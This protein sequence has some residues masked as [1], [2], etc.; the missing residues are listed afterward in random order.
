MLKSIDLINR[1]EEELQQK[2][3]KS[4]IED[5][6]IELRINNKIDVYIVSNKHTKIEQLDIQL[7][8]ENE[9]KNAN[10]KIIFINKERSTNEEYSHLFSGVRVSLGLRRSLN[11]LLNTSN[12]RDNEKN[13]ITFYSYKGGVGRTTSLALT[14]T[15]LSRKGK[16][17]FVIDCDFEAPGLLNFFNS[18][19]ADNCKNGL[20]EYLNDQKFD[21]DTQLSDYVYNIEKNYSGAGIINLIPAGNILS[22]QSDTLSYL[23]GLAKVDFQ[24]D[25]LISLMLKLINE[26]NSNYNP[27]VVLIDSRTGFNNI[28]GALAHISKH[29]VVLAGDDVQNQPG[30]EYVTS[31]LDTKDV[32]AT[33]VLSVISS[34]FSRRANNFKNY[35]QGLS[36]SNTDVDVFYFDR[37]NALEYI[38]T[39][40]E[41]TYDIDD[42]INGEN[43][44][45]QYHNFFQH[46]D[47]IVNHFKDNSVQDTNIKD[48]FDIEDELDLDIEDEDED[49]LNTIIN[50]VNHATNELSTVNTINSIQDIVL[51]NIRTKLPDLYAENINY[52]KEYIDKHFYYRPC[53]EDLLIP[54]KSILLGDKG[55]GKTAFYKALQ[56]NVFFEQ[57]VI[58]AQKQH[59]NYNVVNITNFEI[60]NF[61][62]LGFDE[63][64]KNELFIK[65]FWLFYIWN[66]LCSRHDVKTEFSYNLIELGRPD[67]SRKIISL[68]NNEGE[69]QKI[70][71]EL[72]SIN[73]DLK[74]HDRRLIITFDQLD[75]I[76]KPILW[77]DVVS[78]LVKM[79][80]RFSYSNIHPKLFLRRDLYDRLGNL[81]NKNSFISRVINLEW[82]Q[83]EIF[84]YF[85]KI[86]FTYSNDSFFSFLEYGKITRAFLKNLAKKL[87]TKSKVHNQLPLDRA[88]I[89]P[90]I[91][92]FFGSPR[93]NKRGKLS[94]AYQ[95]L[96]R[97]IQSADR[98]VNLRPFIDLLTNAIQEQDEQDE[99]KKFRKGAI[100]G[101]AYCTSSTVRKNAVVKYLEDLWNEQG[102]EFVKCFCVDFSKNKVDEQFKRSN[103]TEESFEMLLQQIKINNADEYPDISV[104][105]LDDLKQI[106]IATKIVTPYMVGNK[107]RYRIAYLYTNYLGV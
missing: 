96:Y 26:V 57:L 74:K 25:S 77:N 94:T 99:N 66:A 83:N 12:N 13:I 53:M 101:L 71:L 8:T 6:F 82:S 59:L 100:I 62:F 105:T 22:G 20:I 102:N 97:N 10:V 24:G 9:L 11:A 89:E 79:V 103:F 37:Q 29:I 58:K 65:K 106:L 16:N 23:E 4:T 98:T 19:Q 67:A 34:N 42:F 35:I 54:E 75:N 43:G 45:P 73:D 14:A 30:I 92:A 50:D 2:I 31:T 90:V 27:D 55:T 3:E 72:N 32:A 46:I 87:K 88:L 41:D 64:I 95:D 18:S 61:E 39:P 81:T 7:I 70:E 80:M 76:V 85:L 93:V 44:S 49:E 21:V 68:V 84:S 1:F 78:P 17:V 86:V 91:N 69:F 38:G 47:Q 107:T 48:E 51:E 28:F 63:Y 5:Y 52:T 60:E 15:Y 104:S 40:L 36:K 33:Y 56:L